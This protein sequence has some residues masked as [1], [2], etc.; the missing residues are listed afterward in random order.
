[1]QETWVW[2]LSL[3]DPLEKGMATYSSILAWRISWMEELGGLQAMGLQ[4]VRKDWVINIFTF[5]LKTL[6]IYSNTWAQSPSSTMHNIESTI[7]ILLTEI[8]TNLQSSKKETFTVCMMYNEG[9]ES[10]LRCFKRVLNITF[11]IKAFLV[12][13]KLKGNL[14]QYYIPIYFS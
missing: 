13:I 7:S 1:M 10:W 6:R 5:L 4:S 2:S 11:E 9:Q 14:P 3:E 8:L 12:S